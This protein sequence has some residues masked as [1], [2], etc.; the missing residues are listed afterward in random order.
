MST[1][2]A[3]V[4]YK[5][6]YAKIIG[7]ENTKFLIQIEGG[8]EQKVRNKDFRFLHPIFN[9][10]QTSAKADFDILDEL[11]NQNLNINE[12]SE[13]L[14]GEYSPNSAWQT[15]LLIE[16]GLYFFWQTDSIFIRPKAQITSIL[17]KRQM[18][19]QEQQEIERCL[20][21]ITNHCI[22]EKDYKI[23]ESVVKVA[24]LELK[25]AKILKLLKI[26]NTPEQAHK[27]LVDIG[28]W[29]LF[30]N[31]YPERNKIY[32]DETLELEISADLKRVDLTHLDSYAIDNEGSTDADDAISIDN[33]KIWVHIADVA[34]FAK[35]DN[36]LDK[37]AGK[38]LSNLYLP[39][40]VFHMLP[41]KIVNELSLG[42]NDNSKAFSIGFELKNDKINNIEITHSTVKVSNITYEMADKF[43]NSKLKQLF[44]IANIH[45]KYRAENGS[46]NLNLPRVEIK[47]K[48]KSIEITQQQ[49]TPAR[50]MV[51]EFMIMAG[52]VIAEFASI[53]DI[54]MPFIS[55][56]KGNFSD[57]L[58]K[59]KDTMTLAENFASIK[60][61]KRSNTTTKAKAH[62][63]LGLNKY[64][65]ITSPMR[66]Y[67][68]LLAQQQLSNFINNLPILDNKQ[69]KNIIGNYNANIGNINKTVRNSQMHYKLL[70]LLQNKNLTLEGI[71]IEIQKNK[72]IV[73]IKN[74]AMLTQI[75]YNA[76]VGEKLTLKI[77]EIDIFNQTIEFKKL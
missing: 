20:Q 57:E 17:Q 43:A 25:N 46:F 31:P 5:G 23:L 69:I 75:K 77:K 67:L 68:D 38:R 71:V 24:K 26:E 53:N 70:Y 76:K 37:Y 52:R 42:L 7:K 22:D 14:F 45:K 41:S 36:D 40:K 63:G 10:P 8:K 15:Y 16:D 39:E 18:K 54:A 21:N 61:F 1:I 74:L 29:N 47:V 13:W 4:A 2:G 72:I 58:I 30:Y 34:S 19:Q 51:A 49:T 73:A 56:E 62:F 33:D 9:I 60:L 55:Q 65:R 35:F 6:K 3:L 64:L 48:G 28:Y 59:N 50:D 32:K 12:L 27:L 66:R 44:N 11:Q